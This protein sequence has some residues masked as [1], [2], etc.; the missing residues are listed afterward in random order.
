MVQ[1]CLP[2][3]MFQGE[4]ATALDFYLATFPEARAEQ[5]I[6]QAEE[7]KATVEYMHLDEQTKPKE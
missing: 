7:V 3:L 2:F 5:G 6:P 1:S 4:G